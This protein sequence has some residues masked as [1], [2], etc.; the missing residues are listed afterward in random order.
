MLKSDKPQTQTI[1][2]AQ[3]KQPS[4]DTREISPEQE[5]NYEQSTPEEFVMRRN[6]LTSALK[7]FS[8]LITKK[9]TKK[10]KQPYI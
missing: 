7:L 2:T 9:N 1:E 5:I 10:C 6:K 3:S 4:A 8:L